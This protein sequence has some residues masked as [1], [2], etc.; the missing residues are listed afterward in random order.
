MKRCVQNFSVFVH[1]K[2]VVGRVGSLLRQVLCCVAVVGLAFAVSVVSFSVG[3][4]KRLC[5]YCWGAN[6]CCGHELWCA[7]KAS[8]GHP[9]RRPREFQ[10]WSV[11]LP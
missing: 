4:Y 3:W 9:R 6:W 7:I 5:V 8:M 10:L 1:P 2:G 11:S